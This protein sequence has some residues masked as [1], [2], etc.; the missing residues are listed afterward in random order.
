MGVRELGVLE[1][2]GPEGLKPYFSIM[3]ILKANIYLKRKHLFK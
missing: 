1:A 3:L 2:P